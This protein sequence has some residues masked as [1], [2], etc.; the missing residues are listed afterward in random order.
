MERTI[1]LPPCHGTKL[2]C[3][4]ASVVL[5]TAQA[6]Y[7]HGG[8]NLN[9]ILNEGGAVTPF[10]LFDQEQSCL[11]IYLEKA[12]KGGTYQGRFELI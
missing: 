3:A 1:Q 11:E 9:H 10:I 4:P 6:M 8:D 5:N 7:E 2:T 12:L